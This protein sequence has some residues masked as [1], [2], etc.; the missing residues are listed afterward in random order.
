MIK[1]N[2]A[3]QG[4]YWELETCF[5][6]INPV[7]VYLKKKLALSGFEHY[8]FC[9]EILLRE[10]FTNAVIH[11]NRMSMEK[12]INCRII[13]KEKE[14]KMEMADEGNGF[15]WQSIKIYNSK[16]EL[17]ESGRGISI[18]YMYSDKVIFSEKGNSV[19]V[20]LELKKS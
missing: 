6:A 13:L 2:F 9:A 14:L 16:K 10:M 1:K 17:P 4:H 19:C 20:K 12:K 3:P 8:A 15:D 18:Y 7:C 11:G 5:D